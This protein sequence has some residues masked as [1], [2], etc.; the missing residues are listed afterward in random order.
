MGDVDEDR[1]DEIFRA[2]R[3]R[4]GA[5]RP[6]A[7]PSRKRWPLVLAVIA[8]AVGGFLLARKLAEVSRI[9]DCV[10][11]GRKNCAHLDDPN[12]R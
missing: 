10:M 2:T 7:P 1:L 4:P 8:V 12:E 6:P 9:Q 3:P 11:S 5:P